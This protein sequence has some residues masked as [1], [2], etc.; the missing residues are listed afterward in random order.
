MELR[1]RINVLVKLGDYLETDDEKKD[2]AFEL[3]Y[4][5]NKWFTK[6]YVAKAIG[7]IAEYFLR[8]DILI[9]WTSKYKIPVDSPI[10]S[11]GLILAGNI[12]AVGFHDILCCFVAGH[13]A[14]IKTS[15][16]DD[17]L[18]RLLVNKIIELEG[19]A[20]NY[21]EFV[22]R[23]AGFDAVIA[24]GSNNSSSYFTSYFSKYPHIIR[25]NRNGIA[26]ISGHESKA[27]L[28][29]LC[30]DI[31]DYFGMG[32]RSVSKLYVPKDYDMTQFMEITHER[33]AIINHNKYKNNF[34]YN[35]AIFIL[36]K[37][38]YLSNGCLL[39]KEDTQIASRI[40][41]LHYERYD[42]QKSLIEHIQSNI[43]YIQCV[44]SQAELAPVQTIKFGESQIPNIDSYADGV[45]T[46]SFL[47]NL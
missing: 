28:E 27:D 14:L 24:T 29:A 25:K 20:Q 9:S 6:E 21:F 18:I 40:A 2:A 38:V 45:D 16:K 46:L 4:L 35:F 36:N 12:P 39:V 32:C 47:I 43:D 1:E 8:E 30:D 10:K 19:A 37:D 33:K 13:K 22:D 17:I 11:I 44:C 42:D 26:V 34:D 41:S 15:E 5:K 3:A 23:L 7:S 31:F